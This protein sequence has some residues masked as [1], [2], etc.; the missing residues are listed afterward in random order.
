MRSIWIIFGWAGTI[1]KWVVTSV[2]AL[3][4]AVVLIGA[5]WLSLGE[6]Y[7][8]YTRSEAKARD[9]ATVWFVERCDEYDLD[10]NSFRGPE[11]EKSADDSYNF[12]WT[13]TPSE[14][15]FVSVT[16]F[17]YDVGV[18][19]SWDIPSPPDRCWG[20]I[21]AWALTG[22]TLGWKNNW[23]KNIRA[24]D[25]ASC[26]L[27]PQMEASSISVWG[28]SYNSYTE[29]NERRMMFN[30]YG[31][32]DLPP[33]NSHVVKL[34]KGIVDK[35][36]LLTVLSRELRFP[37]YFGYNWDALDECLSD[38]SW[39][40]NTPVCLWHEDIPLASHPDE[41]R[42]YLQILNKVSREPRSG[43]LNVGFPDTAKTRV[44]SLLET[45]N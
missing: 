28:P 36:S 39:L 31:P 38:L 21:L 5:L 45:V 7:A 20:P 37:A 24:P 14:K 26:A 44:R 16:Y 27:G 22:N 15:I 2:L 10:P 29:F 19:A 42:T 43:I 12:V 34:H 18:S 11:L 33:E 9:F 35:G 41:A 23:K 6:S 3:V 13:R 1:L 8:Y 30:F 25:C 32:S 4:L 17:P 40:S